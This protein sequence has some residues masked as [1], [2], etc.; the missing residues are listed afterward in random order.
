MKKV[1]SLS[2]LIAAFAMIGFTSCKK[3]PVTPPDPP[4]KESTEVDFLQLGYIGDAGGGDGYYFYN[5]LLTEKGMVSDGKII[6]GGT[7]YRFILIR[8]AKEPTD[9]YNISLG[10]Y[11]ADGEA[12]PSYKVNTFEGKRSEI[13]AIS[14]D[15]QRAGTSENIVSGTLTFEAN[16]I[17]FKGKGSNG[18]DFDIVYKGSYTGVDAT[19][20]AM[21]PKTPTTITETLSVGTFEDSGDYYKS[22]ARDIYIVLKDAATNQTKQ[23]ITD[24]FVPMEQNT[25]PQ[26]IYPIADTHGVNTTR[27]SPGY[28]EGAKIYEAA[29]VYVDLEANK[30]Y[31]FHSGQA[32]VS[33]DK[34][35][36]NVQSHFGSTLNITYTGT[37][38]VVTPQNA[39]AKIRRF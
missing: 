34:I 16:K 28:R 11:T 36:F 10:E 2:L 29:S 17:T 39:P 35:E 13:F 31:F 19:E 38:N 8:D 32:V 18:N 5:L 25:L 24:L 15:G 3:A 26:G 22:G 23:L 6:K 7:I 37:I 4:A 30:M 33:Q 14:D 20:W 21:E 12:Q 9:N 27:K 1:F